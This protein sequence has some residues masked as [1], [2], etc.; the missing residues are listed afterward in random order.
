MSSPRSAEAGGS[1]V[2]ASAR[3]VTPAAPDPGLLRAALD[4]SDDAV[5]LCTATEH[6]VLLVNAAAAGLVPDLTEVLHHA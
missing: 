4:A 3:V 2:G 5:V 1:P 6:T